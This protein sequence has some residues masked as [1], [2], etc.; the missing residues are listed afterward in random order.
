MIIDDIN[1]VLAGIKGAIR[2]PSYKIISE[3][4]LIELIKSRFSSAY[5]K[6]NAGCV[7]YRG[8]NDYSDYILATPGIRTS[9]N[10]NNFYNRLFSGILPSWKNYPKRNSSFICTSCIDTAEDFGSKVYVVLPENGAKIGI[11]PSDDL[12]NSFG[13]IGQLSYLND[14]MLD[15]FDW[16]FHKYSRDSIIRLF[17]N[18]DDNTLFE[19]L[20][21]LD[22]ELENLDFESFSEDHDYSSIEMD[23]MQ[24]IEARNKPL[25]HFLNTLLSPN[26][27]GFMLKTIEKYNINNESHNLEVWTDSNCI[28]ITEEALSHINI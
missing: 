18:A 9:I 5:K 17:R 26:K 19:H 23:I 6:I 10:T 13:S 16:G 24:M 28:M 20:D 2:L 3:E 27:N 15:L 22:Y 25:P 8:M 11:C 14:V 1:I 12:W 4:Q 7:I 21:E